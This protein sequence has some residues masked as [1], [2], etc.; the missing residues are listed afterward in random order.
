MVQT[1]TEFRAASGLRM[2]IRRFEASDRVAVEK[3][4]QQLSGRARMLRA[5]NPLGEL[6][7]P[8][9]GPP[10]PGGGAFVACDPQSGEILGIGRYAST[11]PG[12]AEVAFAVA[13]ARRDEGI[14]PAL[15]HELAED[16]RAS[17]IRQL[18]AHVLVEHDR[19]FGAFWHSGYAM[20]CCNDGGVTSVTL[21]LAP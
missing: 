16:A 8:F 5:L 15:L 11:N 13:Y 2:V 6:A 18:T 14:G 7:L 4:T 9:A 17:G 3:L 21:T 19:T 20:S 10:A 12:I 1:A